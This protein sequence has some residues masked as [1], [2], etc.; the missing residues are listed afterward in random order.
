[1]AIIGS[2]GDIVFEISKKKIQSFSDFTRT[3]QPRWEEHAILGNKPLPEFDGPG[4][5]TITFSILFSAHLGVNPEKQMAKVREFAR[6]GKKSLFI[7]GNKPISS[8]YWIITEVSEKHKTVDSK[9]N[10]LIIE[11]DLTLLEY[12]NNKAS[13]NNKAK[14]STVKKQTTKNTSKT[15]KK[16]IGTIT[17]TAKSIHIRSGPGTGYKVLGYAMKGD[18]LTIYGIKNGWYMLGGGKY[19]S[20]NS[21]Y[22]T[23]KKG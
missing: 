18:K 9:G 17:I 4:L 16:T 22:S 12:P 10:V 20:S 5:D 14:V 2:F 11:A 1:M 6:K 19:I 13:K 7:R 3:T 23:F 21:A 15:S 8:N